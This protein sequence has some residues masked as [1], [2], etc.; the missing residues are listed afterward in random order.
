[1]SDTIFYTQVDGD[2]AGTIQT[3]GEIYAKKKR[4]SDAL[5]WLVGKSVFAEA[6]V[7]GDAGDGSLFIPKGGGLG[8]N[9]LYSS[10]GPDKSGDKRLLPK[11]HITSVKISSIGDWGSVKTC[12]L[13]FTC[14]SL[15]QLNANLAFCE[16]GAD[17]TVRY[18]WKNGGGAEG[19]PGIFE[20]KV[21][22]FNYAVN[23]SG[24]WD[25]TTKAMA[26][27]IDV[28]SGNV[29]GGKA[30]SGL[31]DGTGL[32]IPR[33]DILSNIKALVVLVSD[34]TNGQ[35]K[36]K[37]FNLKYGCLEY[38]SEWGAA[39]NSE[40][41]KADPAGAEAKEHEKHY[42][43]TLESIV[44]EIRRILVRQAKTGATIKCNNTVTVSPGVTNPNHLISANPRQIVFPGFNKYGD[45]HDFSFD[46]VLTMKSGDVL[47]SSKIMVSID[48]L[49]TL[50]PSLG[51]KED[52][53][54]AGDTSIAAFLGKIFDSIYQNSGRRISLTLSNDPKSKDGKDWLV[55]DTNYA[56]GTGVFVF[57]AFNAYS[58]ARSISIDSKVPNEMATAA[59]VAPGASSGYPA[60]T[61][62][63]K[64]VKKKKTVT[65]QDFETSLKEIKKL[66]DATEPATKDEPSN[67][68]PTDANI[69]SMQSILQ[70][71]FTQKP[72]GSGMSIPYPLGFSITIDGVEGIVFGNT[73]TTTY[74][75]KIYLDKSGT[76][77]VF[78]VTKVNQDITIDDWTTSIETVCRLPV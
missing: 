34:L 19:K 49:T 56:P 4:D 21:F 5:K 8:P 7:K 67:A 75:P 28:V 78:T 44:N 57:N 9:G 18:G 43:I 3:R 22:N 32:T 12:E 42:Y 61:Q 33:F 36:T 30:E 47:D 11:A 37:A 60:G 63:G 17:L 27:G 14:Y 2:V 1:M 72:D 10:S 16:I 26:K 73:V 65:L 62:F 50:L 68:G 69:S 13:A 39:K 52:A 23:S 40:E 66:Y 38:A 74:L 76:K 46:G 41:A 77:V 54:K 53:S 45:K 64:N 29:K 51:E 48:W 24:G 35:T 58:V 55:V 59:F 31:G 70:G 25:C 71:I 15:D 6:S 20:G